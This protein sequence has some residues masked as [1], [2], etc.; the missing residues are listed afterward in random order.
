VSSPKRKVKSSVNQQ[1]KAGL[2]A[3][4]DFLAGRSNEEKVVVPE[5]KATRELVAAELLAAMSGRSTDEPAAMAQTSSSDPQEIP[6]FDFGSGLVQN[7]NEPSDHQELAKP[8]APARA[9]VDDQVQNL[10]EREQERARQLFLDH[11]YF[12]EAVQNLRG[13]SSP[14]ERAAAARALGV[15]GSKRATAHLIAAMFDDDAEVRNAAAAALIQVGEPAASNFSAAAIAADEIIKVVETPAADNV[16]EQHAQP[17]QPIAAAQTNVEATNDSPEAVELATAPVLSAPPENLQH[18]PDISPDLI[19]VDSAASE[20]DP[21]LR[22]AQAVLETVAN[23]EQQQLAAATAFKEMENEVRWRSERETKVRAEAAARRLEEDE[24]RK[25]AEEESEARRRQE[26]E[27]MAIERAARLKAEAEAQRYA[28]E[29]TNLRMKVASLRL[30]AAEI[31]R[32]RAEVE[33]AR[34]EAAE[35]A[36]HAEVMR[37]RDEARSRHESELA[38]LATEKETLQTA[39]DNVLQQQTKVRAGREQAANELER[40]KEEQAAAEAAQKAEAERLRQEAQKA[41][42]EA[43]EQLRQELENLR[44]QGEEVD[45]RR[46]EIE[47][48]REKADEEAQ[49]LVEAQARMQSAEQARAQAEMERSQLEAQINQQVEA[50]HKLLEETRRRGEV[51]LARLKEELRLHAEKE[52]HRAAE[53]E[54]MRT[55]AAVESKALAEKEEQILTQIESLRITD[56]D[57]RRRIEDADVRRRAADDAYR[58]IAE[59]VQRVEAESHARAKEEERMRLKLEAER[60]NAAIAAQSRAEQEKRIREEIEMFRRLEEE[61]RP[62]IEE[63]TLQLADAEARL[64]ERKDRLR[65]EVEDRAVTEEEFI[66]VGEYQASVAEGPAAPDVNERLAPVTREEATRPI[67]RSWSTGAAADEVGDTN[68]GDDIAASVVT[69]AIATYLNSVDP[70]KRAAAVAE[71]ARSGSPDAFNRIVVCF[72]DHSSHVRNAAARAL[73]KLEP[74]RTVDLFNRALEE[75]SA[76]RRRNIGAAIAASGLATDAINNLASESREDT[77]NALSILFV[78]AKTGEVAPL[79]QAVEEHSGDEIGKA[80]SKLL[81]LSGHPG[82][83][84]SQV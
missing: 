16:T 47:A 22:E 28:D 60:R 1:I 68:T 63:A 58:L 53:L 54:V 38:L 83:Q 24:G 25:R 80:V 2:S 55:R 41:N 77:Y 48:S 29:E 17:T 20:E 13:A 27:A 39:T 42:N 74:D 15:V 71:L 61:E 78:M 84:R 79:L 57:T 8:D 26:L 3:M 62:R 9:I 44:H 64:Q 59:K 10:T 12:D 75:A 82:T 69:P 76:D 81:T 70:Y 73:R 46:K 33:K 23:I 32:R 14:I 37:V 4:R 34:Q 72:D 5:D 36:R 18:A 66:T 43:Q 56:A 6:R 7:T 49:R 19:A 31:A 11:G 21:L 45:R 35:A 51:E 30:E 50:Q 67:A 65:Q 40:L 52:Q